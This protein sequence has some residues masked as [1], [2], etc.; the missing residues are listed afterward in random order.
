MFISTLDLFKV[1]IGPS[2]SHTMGPM[3]AAVDFRFKISALLTKQ[4]AHQHTVKEAN[5]VRCTLKGSLAFTGKGHAT[6]KAII[7]G[8]HGFRPKALANI[9]VTAKLQAL[10]TQTHID[11]DEGEI[12]FDPQNNIEFDFGPPLP[13]HTNG[14]I[15]DFVRDGQTVLS[16]TYFSIGGGFITTLSDIQAIEAPIKIHNEHTCP[17]AFDSA[18]SMLQMSHEHKRS[19]AQMKYANEL[20]FNSKKAVDEQLATLWSAMQNCIKLGLN[21]DE[22]LPGE[23][24]IQRRAKQL[25]QQLD[26]ADPTCTVNDWLCAYAMAVNEENA[27]G[28]MVVTAPTNGAAGV[29]PAVLYYFMKHENGHEEQA[30]EFLLTAGAIGGL[31]K[32]KSSISGAEVGCQ[33]E[34][35]SASAMAAAGLCAVRGGTTEQI[36][37]AAEIA[38]EHHLGMTCD[39][40]AGLVQVPCI[41]RNG[42]GAIK[43]YTAAS[44]ALRGN[45]KHFM[46]L[47][48]CIQAM[49]QTGLEMSHK[50]KETSL[51]G[52]AVSITEC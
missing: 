52:L 47:D 44:L 1:G 24:H 17:F 5:F 45:G 34:V 9:N 8:L 6:D 15:F 16:E 46:P 14:L 23:L 42:F 48:S 36:E 26:N 13:E 41:E 3:E 33:G 21:A 11:L 20:C 28:H 29:V 49:K 32:H 51:G 2:S 27:A 18:K 39:P 19:I 4:H 10:E 7:L 35:G 25:Y 30:Q 31:I 43:A 37:N 50:Y 12:N 38:L 22:I 40:V